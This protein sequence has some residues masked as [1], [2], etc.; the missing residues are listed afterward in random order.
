MF[1]GLQF[2][3]SLN[4]AHNDAK[5][6]NI[7]MDWHPIFDFPPHGANPARKADWSGLITYHNHTTHPV[8]HYFIDWNLSRKYDSVDNPPLLPP[9]YG[10]DQTVPEFKRN[11]MCNPFAVDV[12]CMGNVI[13]RRFID[14]IDPWGPARR[15]VEFLNDL[16][17][18]MTHDDPSKRPTMDEVVSRFEKIRNGLSWWKLR[19]RVSDRRISLFWHL[20]YSPIHWAVQLSY[21]LRRIPAIP[22]YTTSSTYSS[23]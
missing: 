11:E 13:Q 12:Y 18:D 17:S 20:L 10:G 9:G 5:D 16:I 22:D 15:N 7:M 3:H 8:K 2:M 21:I 14:G 1:E 23:T 19:C 6:T 4:I